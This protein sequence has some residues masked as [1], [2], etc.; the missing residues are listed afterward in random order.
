MPLASQPTTQR[1]KP[2]EGSGSLLALTALSIIAGAFTGLVVALF[3]LTLVALDSWRGE[4]IAA[5]HAR[6]TIGLIVVVGVVTGATALAAW[7]VRRFEPRAAGSGIP[8]VEAVLYEELPPKTFRLIP[9]KFVGGALSIGA[10][11]AL[12]R[13]GPSVEM[14]A[15]IARLVAVAFR[16]DWPDCRALMAAGAGA[17]LATAFNAPIAGAVFIF[18][19]MVQRVE[20]RITIATLGATAAAISVARV[21]LGPYTDFKLEPLPYPGL[22]LVPFFFV[23]GL[24]AGLAGIA[25]NRLI[26]GAQVVMLRLQRWS[27]EGRAAMIG[28]VVGLLAWFAPELVGGGDA[29]T[30]TILNDKMSMSLLVGALFLRFF[31]GPVSYAA[32]TPG[33][34]FAPM[35]VPG[36]AFGLLGGHLVRA[37]LP[38]L[39]PDP[40]T[41]AVVGMAAFFTAVVRSPFTGIVLVAEMTAG[42]D[43]L[44]PMLAACLAAMLVPTH[45]NDPPIYDALRER[46][47]RHKP[48]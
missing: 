6:P 1:V 48:S 46:A 42:F 28:A 32:G 2:V 47:L 39:A 29:V 17:G 38:G 37:L 36:A 16:R 3:R 45:F 25:Y 23:L 21:L 43:I 20:R 34:L 40:V 8:D 33:G 26:V 9:V 14:G 24:A 7:L 12:G 22:G 31:L 15:V 13:E 30:Q 5:W 44:L 19:E 35:L 10:G 4:Y 41:F 18:E 27:A 11:Q